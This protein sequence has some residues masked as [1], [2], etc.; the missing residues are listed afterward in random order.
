MPGRKSRSSRRYHRAVM[1]STRRSGSSPGWCKHVWRTFR[2]SRTGE[3]YT[4]C[5]NCYRVE[6]LP[7]AS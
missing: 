6:P 5:E 4:Y 7:P 1:A 2:S 3:A